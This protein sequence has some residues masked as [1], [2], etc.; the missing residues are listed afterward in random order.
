MDFFSHFCWELVQ[1]FCFCFFNENMYFFFF[2][3]SYWWCC[4]VLS[5][6][7]MLNPSVMKL[8]HSFFSLDLK[9]FHFYAVNKQMYR[10]FNPLFLFWVFAKVQLNNKTKSNWSLTHEYKPVEVVL[11]PPSVRLNCLSDWIKGLT[12]PLLQRSD[13]FL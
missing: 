9:C 10:C 2:P 7:I 13:W 4:S 6:W 11:R 5:C 8:Q 12:V 3:P 1:F